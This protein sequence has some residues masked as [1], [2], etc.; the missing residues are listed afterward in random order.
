MNYLKPFYKLKPQK[1]V[2]KHIPFLFLNKGI[3]NVF[4]LKTFPWHTHLEY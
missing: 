1:N 3:L 2:K 4:V